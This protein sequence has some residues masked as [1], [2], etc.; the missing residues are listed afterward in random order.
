[1]KTQHSIH[2]EV[3]DA[4]EAPIYNETKWKEV[5]VDKIVVIRKGKKNKMPKVDLQ[6]QDEFG[7]NYIVIL[8]GSILETV[9]A[10]VDK[11]NGNTIKRVLH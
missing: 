1:M 2:I 8:D 6:I 3:K 9:G 10:M 4:K 5:R 11:E 7:R